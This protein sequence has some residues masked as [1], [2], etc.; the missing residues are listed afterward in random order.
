MPLVA[1]EEGSF[2]FLRLLACCGFFQIVP[3]FTSDDVVECFGLQIYY[4]S[5]SCRFYNKVGQLWSITK[6]CKCYYKV[7]ELFLHYKTWQLVL[8]SRAG[9]TKWDNFYLKFGQVLQSGAIIK[10]SGNRTS[11]FIN[12]SN[13]LTLKI[14]EAT[15][16]ET[17]SSQ[18]F[19]LQM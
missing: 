1:H 5:A 18:I 6:K 17:M 15:F 16:K 7:G 9:I 13:S 19:Y 3:L 14:S 11:L 12:F 8:R 10:K 2:S 4:K